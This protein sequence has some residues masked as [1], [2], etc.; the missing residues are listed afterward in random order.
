MWFLIGQMYLGKKYDQ[1]INL[2]SNSA[3]SVYAKGKIW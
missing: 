1:K 2:P 3:H